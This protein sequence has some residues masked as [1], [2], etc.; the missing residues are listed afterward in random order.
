[1]RV[2]TLFKIV[3]VLVAALVVS[4]Y[5]ILQSQDFSQYRGLIEEQARAAT[6]RELVLAGDLDLR[7]LSLSPA[8]TVDDVTLKNASW[9]TRPD[10]VTLQRLEAEVALLPLFSGNLTVK[11]LVLVAPEIFLETDKQGRGNWIF[12]PDKAAPTP[13]ET[14]ED[15]SDEDAPA[16]AAGMPSLPVVNEARIE[17]ARLT[18]RDGVTETEQHFVLR[19]LGANARDAASPLNLEGAGEVDGVAFDFSARLGAPSALL[20]GT[21]PYGVK[22]TAHAG[23]AELSLDGT[24]KKPLAGSGLDIQVTVSGDDLSALGAVTGASLPALGPYRV[25]G[26]FS[27]VK[28][29]Y[30]LRSLELALGDSDLSGD[31][32]IALGGRTKL[33]A[34]LK[35]RLLNLANFSDPTAPSPSTEDK[36]RLFSPDPLPLD[37]L[38]GIDADLS[39]AA[40]KMIADK[41]ILEDLNLKLALDKGIL[42]LRPLNVRLAK[43]ALS[44]DLA[45]N[46]SQ[47]QTSLNLNVTMKDLDMGALLS[48]LSDSGAG[49][50]PLSGSARATLALRGKGDSVAALMAGLQGKTSFIMEKGVLHDSTFDLLSADLLKSITP[51]AGDKDSNALNCAVS[52][53]HIRAGMAVSQALLVDTSNV[54]VSG[55]GGVNLASEAI[56]LTLTP[57]TR[58]LSLMSL[59]VPIKI[60]GTLADPTAFPDMAGVVTGV[61]KGVTEGVAGTVTGAVTGTAGVVGDILTAPLGLFGDG[62]KKGGEEQAAPA[63]ATPSDDLCQAAISGKKPAPKKAAPKETAPKQAAP[64]P[65]EPTPA[66]QQPPPAPAPAPTPA[67]SS[68][69]PMPSAPAPSPQSAPGE[70]FGEDLEGLGEGLSKGLKGLF[71]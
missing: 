25:S 6:G 11:R 4:L 45:L 36:K 2:S 56:D 20:K 67:P 47:P 22:L 10:M 40:E 64:A 41:L 66:P 33:T 61:V 15:I 31:L 48:A 52:R 29:G 39:L 53:F 28:G 1:M 21:K 49:S 51:W 63:A 16:P 18:F 58:D 14:P 43:G 59:A 46:A 5:A 23:G 35:S 62:D 7:L 17:N 13:K 8:L 19:H 69:S 38:R 34:K 60:G 37:G 57:R 30:S 50:A 65:T 55:E 42:V 27:D 24:I 12:T 26:R 9:G 68:P 44:G 54:S 71:N 32:T 3:V 70:G